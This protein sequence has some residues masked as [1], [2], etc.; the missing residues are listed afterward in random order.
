VGALL[1]LYLQDRISPMGAATGVP[2]A[3]LMALFVAAYV[4]TR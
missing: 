3:I 2:D 4:K 1:V